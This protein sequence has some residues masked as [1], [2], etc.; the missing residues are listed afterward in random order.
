MAAISPIDLVSLSDGE[1]I[2][3]WSGDTFEL[4]PDI[5]VEGSNSVACTQTANGAN[6]VTYNDTGTW[7]L[8]NNTLRMYVN[9]T[10]VGNM[11]T[12]TA[13]QVGIETQF[14]TVFATGADY[15][16]G[17]VDLVI[18]TELF[19]TITL[20]TTDDISCRFNTASK[21]RNVP[22]NGWFDN[23]RALNGLTLTSTTTEAYDL[24][25]AAALDATSVY[26]VLIDKDG[27]IFAVGSVVIGDATNDSN[28]VSENETMVF[29]DRNVASDLYKLEFNSGTG[30][31]DIDIAGMVCKTVNS[32]QA[33]EF[34]LDASYD[35]LSISGSSFITMGTM[36]LTPTVTTPTFS[37]N[38]FTGCGA[39]TIGLDI[40]GCSFTDCNTVTVNSG[41]DLT[42]CNFIESNAS[43][44]AVVSHLSQIVECDFVSDGSNH[45]V[46]LSSIGGGPMTWDATLSGYV[47]G[48][49]GSP[50]STSSTGNE[51][52]YV[53]VGSGNLTISIA[54]GADIPSVRTAG[55]TVNIVANTVTVRVTARTTAGTAVQDARVRLMRVSD[56]S[57]IL[58][59][60]TNASGVI[61]DT[62]YTYTADEAVYGW[63]RKSSVTPFYKEGPLSGTITS[64][65]YNQTAILILDE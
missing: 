33:A 43:S 48:A 23:W 8:S 54:D 14:I 10:I 21:P 56:D 5:K 17:W 38:S 53:N 31:T 3:G 34:L 65:G 41:S 55:A 25:D 28:F 57:V 27:V 58:G 4:E 61:E 63:A 16:G 29:P 32:T 30:T 59:G 46:E 36:T 37:G 64:G 50:V 40:D 11:N 18:D 20:T 62:A 6:T 13:V 47:A 49:A 42:G 1:S 9:T 44:S 2:T 7:D 15:G 12:S 52:L 51:A 19:T 22:Q 35:S 45:A 60:L 39:A 24:S 26:G